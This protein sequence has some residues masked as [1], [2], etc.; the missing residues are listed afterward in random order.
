MSD[1]TEAGAGLVDG[2]LGLLDQAA[3]RIAERPVTVRFK[4]SPGG[5]VRGEL[6]VVVIAVTSVPVANLIVD[7]LVIHAERVRV[8]PGLPAHL[9]AGPVGIKAVVLQESVD[10]WT[11]AARLPLRLELTP[12]G[13]LAR[14]GIGGIRMGEL[15]TELTVTGQWLQLKPVRASMLG[16]P[17]PVMSFLRGFLPLPPLPA[18][19]R[20]ER[21]EPGDGKLS[22]FVTLD[23]V[24]EA[25]TPDIARRVRNRLRVPGLR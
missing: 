1:E 3:T 5:L 4:T 10:Q 21:V 23:E 11:H 25:L 7:R 24:D 2:L 15:V 16:V 9:R 13:V 12:E 6:D 20:L 8:Q 14:T 18:G 22:V 17:A 19:A